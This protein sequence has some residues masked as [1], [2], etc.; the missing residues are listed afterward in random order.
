MFSDILNY[1]DQKP[2]PNQVFIFLLGGNNLRDAKRGDNAIG[3]AISRFQTIL[4]AIKKINARVIICGCIPDPLF[5]NLDYQFLNMD[6]A[7]LSS[8]IL[9]PLGTFI[10]LRTPVLNS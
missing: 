7:A 8:L 6:N 5:P 1:L 9:G 2:D 3:E 10:E 4:E